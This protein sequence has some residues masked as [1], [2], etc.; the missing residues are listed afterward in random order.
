MTRK[1]KICKAPAIYQTAQMAAFCSP[2]HGYQLALKAIER[3]RQ[4][5]EKKARAVIKE[6]KAALNETVRYW[7]KKAKDAF[8]PWIRWRD[9]DMPCIS[10]GRSVVEERYGGSWDAG[11]YRSVGAAKEL[12]F[13][14]LNVHRQCKSCNAGS[15][16]YTRKAGTVSAAYRER[17][18]DRIGLAKVEWLEGPHEPKRYRVEDLKAIAQHYRQKLREEKA[19]Y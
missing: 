1:C 2:E 18:I 5:E 7:T 14:P 11:H 16:K 13:E 8:H 3:K 9:R 15:G 12:E 10:C 19:I 4:L 6:R 17:L